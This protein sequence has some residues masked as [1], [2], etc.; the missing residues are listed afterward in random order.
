MRPGA[1]ILLLFA[2]AAAAEERFDA[3]VAIVEPFDREIRR[4]GELLI[5]GVL[6]GRFSNPEL[7]LVAPNGKTYLNKQKQVAGNTFLF[8]VRFEEGTGPYR[9]EMVAEDPNWM[10]SAFRL[11]VWH[12]VAAPASPEPPPDPPKFDPLRAARHDRLLEKDFLH[13]LNAFRR[14]LKLPPA[15]WNEAVSARAREHAGRMAKSRRLFHRFGGVGVVQMLQTNGAGSD[16]AS[17]PGDGWLNVDSLRPFPAP[18]PGPPGPKV[19]NHVV[20]FVLEETSMERIFEI[21]FVREPAFRICA[22]DPHLLEVGVGVV[23]LGELYF[24]ASVNFVQVNDTSL[25]A[26]QE[27]AHDALLR[28][29]ESQEP[30]LL[31]RVGVWGRGGRAMRLLEKAWRSPDPAVAAAAFDG[32]QLLDE[33]A[34][35]NLFDEAEGRA[36]AEL[37]RRRY[38]TAEGE[39]RPFEKALFDPALRKR[40]TEFLKEAEKL[41]ES[42]LAAALAL[43]DPAAR[44]SALENIFARSAGTSLAPK[45][46]AALEA[47]G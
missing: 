10:K 2:A 38:A 33:P 4:G 3:A 47:P 1:A 5:R 11:D 22:A 12:G 32:I 6:K 24:F 25:R 37:E 23:H 18:S 8:E 35:L 34:A 43:P 44:R 42:E 29:A 7:I 41:A 14:E 45:V 39:M 15:A 20:P 16:G 30:D 27:R 13:I 26:R 17:G 40:R 28:A 31:R 36:R 9:L 46:A 21:Y 19:W